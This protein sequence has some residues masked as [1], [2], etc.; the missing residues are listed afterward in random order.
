MASER[1]A[2]NSR[3]LMHTCSGRLFDG[4]IVTMV[5]VYIDDILL[6]SKT[7]ENEER[8]LPDLGL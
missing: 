2:S 5:M 1:R 8:T 3:T 7:K 6:V 4:K